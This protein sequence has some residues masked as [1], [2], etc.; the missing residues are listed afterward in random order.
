[1]HSKA[2][3]AIAS[4]LAAAIQRTGTYHIL[5]LGSG[6]AGPWI[7]LQPLLRQFGADV[8]VCLSVPLPE[9]RSLGASALPLTAGPYVSPQ[10]RRC[11]DTASRSERCAGAWSG[12]AARANASRR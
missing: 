5:D 2:Y 3:H 1:V 10:T 9:Y 12:L 7:E 6:A 8:S 11:Q 4:I